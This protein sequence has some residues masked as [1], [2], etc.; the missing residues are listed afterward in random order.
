METI[1]VYHTPDADDAFMFYALFNGKVNSDFRF[2]EKVSDIEELNKKIMK[3]DIE[4]S[5]VSAYTFG[6]IAHDYYALAAGG[7]FGEGY[8]PII[9][10]NK[11]MEATEIKNAS[12]GVP[13]V[14]TTS[15]LLYRLITQAKKEVIMRFDN[16]INSVLKGEVET[17]LLI[18]EGQLTYGHFGLFKVLDL[19]KWWN[20][21]CRDLPMPLGLNVVNK[22]FGLAEA[23]KIKTAM[24]QS[25]RYA[26][27]HP[28]E[29]IKFASKFARATDMVT[30]K[31]F[32]LQYVNETTYDMGQKGRTAIIEL[33]KMATEKGLL[34]D[35]TNI[36]II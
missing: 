21:R 24:Q 14:N 26:M 23:T 32:A 6:R 27:N 18:H 16:I 17:G 3:E 20:E 25:I 31:R 11:K 35:Y 4:V 9:V 5:A 13:G 15:Y 33:M 10:S 29:A 22:K 2:E 12:I 28:D 7:S 36:E 34:T 8:G 30:L 19:F 1:E